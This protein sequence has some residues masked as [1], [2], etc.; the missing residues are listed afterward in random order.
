MFDSERVVDG[1]VSIPV[2][3]ATIIGVDEGNSAVPQGHTGRGVRRRHDHPL[4][5]RH[6]YTPRTATARWQ[7]PTVA[8]DSEAEVD[9]VI[10]VAL[11]GQL[12][13]GVTRVRDLGDRRWCVI[14]R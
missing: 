3:G 12:A 6:S 10:T 4:P 2:E 8:G 5:D 13:A 11:R 1:R 14:E 7:H 9:A